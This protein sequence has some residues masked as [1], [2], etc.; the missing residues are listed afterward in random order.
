[1]PN[2]S[3]LN[4][5]MNPGQI[6]FNLITNSPYPFSR[7][8][9]GIRMFFI[10]AFDDPACLVNIRGDQVWLP[11][12]HDLPVHSIKQKL[13]DTLPRRLGSYLRNKDGFLHCIDV[14]ANVGD[15]VFAFGK[16]KSDRFVA[17]EP[18]AKL[19]KYLHLNHGADNRVTIIEALCS[20]NLIPGNFTF[21]EHGGT[22]TAIPDQTGNPCKVVTLD[23][24]A[25]DLP[26]G[27]APN[28]VKID[29]E[30]FDFQVLKGGKCLLEEFRPAILFECAYFEGVSGNFVEDVL[31]TFTLLEETGYSKVTL[32]DHLGWMMG[33]VPLNRKEQIGLLLHYHL[34][35]NSLYFDVLCLSDIMFENFYPMESAYFASLIGNPAKRGNATTAAR[36]F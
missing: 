31:Q 4:L 17:I 26:R 24:I 27:A 20:D 16:G 14:G 13:Y 2:I 6:I 21:A 7:I 30:G 1:M 36:L 29:T 28:M 12:S 18:H 11:L 32:Y 5:T 19:S 15:S 34:T 9:H 22:A 10:K 3:L 23:S 25:K 8:A 35:R 33:A